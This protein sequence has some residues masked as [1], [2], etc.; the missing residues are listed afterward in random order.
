[1]SVIPTKHFIVTCDGCS[2][3]AVPPLAL[4]PNP[5]GKPL[6][7]AMIA[8]PIHARDAAHTEGWITSIRTGRLDGK[9]DD[10]CP[11]CIAT[12]EKEASR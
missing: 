11:A 1:V 6:H 9:T 2:A 8:D 7:G 4:H 10:L 12:A 5:Y 3:Y